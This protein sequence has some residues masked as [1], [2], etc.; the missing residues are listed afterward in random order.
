MSI[1]LLSYVYFFFYGG[2]DDILCD[3][4]EVDMGVLFI[5]MYFFLLYSVLQV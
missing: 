2:S 5:Y 1:V 4:F 3:L